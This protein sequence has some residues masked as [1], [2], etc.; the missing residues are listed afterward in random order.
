MSLLFPSGHRN[1]LDIPE[2][3]RPERAAPARLP[4]HGR[5]GAE[6]LLVLGAEYLAVK[7]AGMCETEVALLLADRLPAK[8]AGRLFPITHRGS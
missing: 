2:A 4:A 1:S 7:S 5:A 3:L 8:R 6:A